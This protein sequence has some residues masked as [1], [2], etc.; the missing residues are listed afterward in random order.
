MFFSENVSV[1]DSSS[2]TFS[3]VK[4][5]RES[6]RLFNQQTLGMLVVNV[7]KSIFG[8]VFNESDKSHFIILDDSGKNVR[9]IIVTL[10]VL[11]LS[12]IL[13]AICKMCFR[14]FRKMA[15]SLGS[16]QNRTNR[17]KFLFTLLKRKNCLGN[18]IIF[19]KLTV[20]LA[21]LMALISLFL[22][23]VVS[24][25]INMPLLQLKKVTVD[26]AKAR[27]G[28]AEVKRK[29]EITVIG[30]TFK[31]AMTENKELNGA[32]GSFPIKRAG[33]RIESSSG[34]D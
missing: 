7:K 4:L 6:D 1:G 10:P 26:W 13:G 19:G 8:G 27:W 29:D 30:E 18:R 28:G 23:F 2:D 25:K 5:L 12:Q 15:T 31:R 3:S 22:S 32:A 33:I 21:F 14:D 9:N 20:F 16:F 17:L 34:A 11:G 24:G